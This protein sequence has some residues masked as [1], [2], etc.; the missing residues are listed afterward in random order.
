MAERVI[1]DLGAN[2]GMNIPCCL[3]KAQGVVAVEVDP[4]LD[5][6]PRPRFATEIAFG[7]VIV[8][9]R[10]VIARDR[11]GEFVEFFVYRSARPNGHVA[12]S[13]RRLCTGRE[14]DFRSVIVGI[15]DLFLA[16]RAARRVEIREH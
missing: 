16:R 10:A 6:G 13:L 2:T 5:E 7:R 1:Y 9:G 11:V 4:D 3:R 15:V 8:A 14:A 12:S